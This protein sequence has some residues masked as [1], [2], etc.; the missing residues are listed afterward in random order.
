VLG[1]GPVLAGE[2][3]REGSLYLQESV[4]LDPLGRERKLRA[5]L[6]VGTREQRIEAYA[7]LAALR[8]GNPQWQEG[9][10]GEFA[11]GLPRWMSEQARQLCPIPNV[12]VPVELHDPQLPSGFNG[13]RRGLI[14]LPEAIPPAELKGQEVLRAPRLGEAF[15]RGQY[16]YVWQPDKRLYQALLGGWELRFRV[17]YPSPDLSATYRDYSLLAQNVL[18]ALL[19]LYWMGREYLNSEPLFSRDYGGVVDVWLCEQGRAGGEQWLHNIFFYEVTAVRD[20][21]EWLR[22]TCH[23]YSHHIIWPL[24]R[25]AASHYEEWVNGDVGERLF[26]N[27]WLANLP[28]R[29][30]D[31]LSWERGAI[32]EGLFEVYRAEVCEPALRRFLEAG[33]RSALL[34]DQGDEGAEYFLGFVQYVAEAHGPQV[35]ADALMKYTLPSR[36]GRRPADFMR[37]YQRALAARRPRRFSLHPRYYIPSASQVTLTTGGGLQFSPGDY[38]AYHVYL[39]RGEWQLILILSASTESLLSAGWGGERRMGRIGPVE[40]ELGP[41]PTYR[42]ALPLGP[43]FSGRAEWQRLTLRLEQGKGLWL[44]RLTWERTDVR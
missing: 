42:A 40:S 37:G 19:R 22:Q 18:K 26:L 13:T 21:L 3:A 11:Q 24:G 35:L 2:N 43:P 29:P 28:T 38:A 27:W 20:G 23:E 25:F 30:E 41:S 4:G 34:Y 15:D 5:A 31:W 32:A 9:L 16:G 39:P 6:E 7:Q 14:L 10:A 1:N 17:F 12:E 44:H 33:P 36:S 8:P